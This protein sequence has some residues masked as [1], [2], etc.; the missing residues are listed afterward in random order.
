MIINS[1]R[2]KFYRLENA[3]HDARAATE[4]SRLGIDYLPWSRSAL[5]PAALASV[6]NDVI[7][8]RRKR[9]VELG[10][11]IST[12][13]LA[14]VLARTGG[15]LIS[16]DHNQEWLGIVED[17]LKS[18]D[19][20][21]SVQLVEAPLTPIRNSPTSLAWYDTNA[22]VGAIGESEVDLVL[23]DGPL[24]HDEARQLARYPAFPVLREKLSS[25]CALMLDDADRTGEREII[26]RWQALPDFDY[27]VRYTQH[28][29]AVLTRGEAYTSDF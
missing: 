13:Y 5:R 12:I 9:V 6:L 1:L 19:L 21:D 11:G 17:L 24:A 8:N 22:V 20:F 23:I 14:K 28:G 16:V 29:L 3:A 26:K 15:Q 2:Q 18:H 27:T 4:L 7:V 10:A 25:R